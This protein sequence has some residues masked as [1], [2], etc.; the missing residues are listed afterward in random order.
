VNETLTPEQRTREVSLRLPMSWT[1]WQALGETRH[2]EWSE[3]VLYVNPPNKWHVFV[4]KALT[5]R[6]D[7]VCPP[8]LTAIPEWGL[9]T[10]TGDFEPDIMVAAEDQPDVANYSI[11]VPLLVIEIGSPTTR[12][13]DWERKL[14]AYAEYGVAWYWIVDRSAVTVFENV[15]GAFVQR[16]RIEAGKPEETV[17]P[18]RLLLDPDTLTTY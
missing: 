8:G 4:S 17:G 9:R 3:G 11:V 5:R 2:H 15:D 13:L 18:L 7:E 10:P 6:L 16:Q 14:R 1:E 12:D